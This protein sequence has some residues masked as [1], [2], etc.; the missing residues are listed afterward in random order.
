MTLEDIS[1]VFG[2]PVELSFEQALS[3]EGGVE[4]MIEGGTRGDGMHT[5][6]SVIA[7]RSDHEKAAGNDGESVG[8][9]R[10]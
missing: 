2:D 6:A 9:E 3:K 10:V 7:H 8:I 5:G 4:Q 1:V